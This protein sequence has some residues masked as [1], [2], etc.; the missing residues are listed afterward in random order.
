MSLPF[1][2]WDALTSVPR[3]YA[4]KEPPKEKSSL[5][6]KNGHFESHGFVE[7]PCNPCNPLT[8]AQDITAEACLISSLLS[9]TTRQ[10]LL[11]QRAT[12]MTARGEKKERKLHRSKVSA[13]S[14]SFSRFWSVDGEKRKKK[15]KI[16]TVC[17][18]SWA[19]ATHTT[20]SPQPMLLLQ[21]VWLGTRICLF[22]TTNLLLQPL[23]KSK[24]LLRANARTPIPKLWKDN[25]LEREACEICVKIIQRRSKLHW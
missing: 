12:G 1:A 10:A 14:A 5:I 7:Y 2:I 16:K 19:Y 4:V 8:P 6:V 18:S 23:W 11:S 15:N 3:H 9:L 13:L 24:S 17:H 22:K 20:P 21:L 25:S